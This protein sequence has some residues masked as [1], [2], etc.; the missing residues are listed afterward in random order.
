MIDD[1]G[2]LLEVYENTKRDNIINI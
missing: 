2:K 1:R